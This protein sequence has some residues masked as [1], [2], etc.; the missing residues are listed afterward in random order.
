M[1]LHLWPLL[2]L[3]PVIT[4][5]PSTGI[6][7]CTT[8]QT[9]L[10]QS[11]ESP[12]IRSLAK[13]KATKSHS[14]KRATGNRK[15]MRSHSLQKVRDK[16]NSKSSQ[17]TRK[18]ERNLNA[19]RVKRITGYLNGMSLRSWVYTTTISSS[20]VNTFALT[21]QFLDILFKTLQREASAVLKDVQRSIP[22]SLTR[23]NCRQNQA[24]SIK[25]INLASKDK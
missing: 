22:H 10:K 1:L 9:S 20:E 6:L 16:A 4:F 13:F 11:Q 14:F 18:K 12:T 5:M 2:H 7:T 24:V 15:R 19:F 3:R 17:V 25:N 23:N 21:V 8:W